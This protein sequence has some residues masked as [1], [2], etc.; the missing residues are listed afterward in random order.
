M[1]K[2]EKIRPI[3]PTGM[4]PYTEELIPIQPGLVDIFNSN[5]ELK[6]K[7][8]VDEKRL[9]Q[10]LFSDDY[11]SEQEIRNIINKFVI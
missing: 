10:F 11:K 7:K 5:P 6:L 1:I 8:K 9:W 3:V 2:I 4:L